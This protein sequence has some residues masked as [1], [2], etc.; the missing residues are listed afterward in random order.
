LSFDRGKHAGVSEGFDRGESA[1]LA[2]AVL[3]VLE[4]RGMTVPDAARERILAQKDPEQLQRW[5]KKGSVATSL[6]DVLEE[7]S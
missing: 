3:T 4:V 5:L 2:R 6:D 7:R 1:A